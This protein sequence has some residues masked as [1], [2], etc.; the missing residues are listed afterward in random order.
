MPS[1]AIL[2]SDFRKGNQN[3]VCASP[4]GIARLPARLGLAWMQML[5]IRFM[6]KATNAGYSAS[7][8]GSI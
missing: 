3:G 5:T 7:F 8:A 4:I 1:S 6:I 2:H